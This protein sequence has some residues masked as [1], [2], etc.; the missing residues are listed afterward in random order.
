MSRAGGFLT[1]CFA[2]PF[3]NIE[4]SAADLVH[5][6]GLAELGLIRF[7]GHLRKGEYDVENVNE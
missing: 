3:D 7:G 5:R 4:D 6:K 2:S 1:Q